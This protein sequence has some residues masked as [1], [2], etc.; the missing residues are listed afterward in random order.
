MRMEAIEWKKSQP[1]TEDYVTHFEKVKGRFEYAPFQV[2]ELR[3]RAAWLDDAADKQRPTERRAALVEALVQLN[4]RL[5]NAPQ[6]LDRIRELASSETLA[7]VGGQQAGLLTGQLL[8]IYKAVTILHTAKQAEAALGRRVVPVFWIAGEDHDFDEVNHWYTLTQQLEI[9]KGKLDH[10]T[11]I[12]TSVSRLA[13]DSWSEAWEHLDAML[14]PSEF[15]SE[16]MQKLTDIAASSRTLTEQFGQIMAWLFGSEGL[17]LVDSDAPEIRALEGGMFGA[18]IDNRE[19]LT[20]ALLRAKEDVERLGYRPAA[21]VSADNANLF[22]FDES[23]ER[24]LLHWNGSHFTDKRGRVSFTAAE[25]AAE[26]RERPEAFSNNVLT[27]PLMQEY[28]FPVL[29][30]VLGPG[31]VAYWA[32]TREAFAE[33][34]MRMPI[35]VPRMEFTLLEGTVQ[36]QM[37]KFGLSFLDIIHN[38]EEKKAAWLKEQ[39]NLGLEELFAGVKAQ[40]ANLYAPVLQ[41]VGSINA[42]MVKLGETNLQKIMEQVAFLEARATEAHESQFASALR[43]WERSRLSILPMGKPQERVYNIF[44]YLNKYGAGWLR[45]LLEAPI[46]ADGKHRVI[47]F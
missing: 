23:G 41:T 36:K 5:G 6:A 9:D 2:S 1:I 38:Y 24:M 12:R 28:L 32:L 37:D 39:D 21:E 25:L 3:R 35:V 45:E 20:A 46:E 18:L 11:G 43:H 42:G 14:P 15:K 13:I 34:G 40:F 26:A 16:L 7:V 31:E 30:T 47:Y 44:A 22:R 33:M 19:H 8:V 17:V 27:R 10:P 29:S 4:E